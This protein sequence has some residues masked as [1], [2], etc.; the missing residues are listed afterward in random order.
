[1]EAPIGGGGCRAPDVMT[2]PVL[3][4]SFRGR[5][6]VPGPAP[7]A[8]R[9]ICRLGRAMLLGDGAPLILDAPNGS[10]SPRPSEG[11]STPFKRPACAETSHLSP[12]PLAVRSLGLPLRGMDTIAVPT[13]Q[14]S[15]QYSGKHF[16][17][18]KR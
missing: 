18:R 2:P 15:G 17:Q 14:G 4:P 13:V 16:A 12:N 5:Q 7:N 11:P 6:N 1:M 8:S 3:T 10:L 9:E